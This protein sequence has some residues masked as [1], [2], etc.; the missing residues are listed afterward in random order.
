MLSSLKNMAYG[1]EM[2]GQQIQPSGL[3]CCYR[4]SAVYG[5]RARVAAGGFLTEI[6]M[7]RFPPMPEGFHKAPRCPGVEYVVVQKPKYPSLFVFVQQ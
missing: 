4:F 2:I 5:M 6:S 3:L 1:T 7:R